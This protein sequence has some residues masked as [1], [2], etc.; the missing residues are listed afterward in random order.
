MTIIKKF[1]PDDNGVTKD[2][3]FNKKA[4]FFASVALLSLILIEIWITNTSV[5]FGEKFEKLRNVEKNLIL[6][7]QILE[8]QIAKFLSLQSIASVSAKLGF[9]YNPNI[10]YIR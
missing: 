6:E 3:K 7:N 2:F 4:I 1:E 5:T 10:Q 8:N 9:S